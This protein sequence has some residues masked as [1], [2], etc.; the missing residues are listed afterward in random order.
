MK[1]G[2][3]I[4]NIGTLTARRADDVE[5]DTHAESLPVRDAEK[6]AVVGGLAG[7]M[8]GLTELAA[9][10]LGALLAG[11][12]I[13]T[14]LLGAGIG[15]AAGGLIGALAEL[16]LPHEHAEQYEDAVRRGGVVLTVRADPVS[17]PRVRE[18]LA[19]HH[20]EDVHT[21]HEERRAA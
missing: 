4:E 11:G 9:P 2:I 14:T 21:R 5:L 8:L 19:Y 7:L 3:P 1:S 12:W 20:A 17:V 18:I 16:G 15:A 13:V 6:G 10:G